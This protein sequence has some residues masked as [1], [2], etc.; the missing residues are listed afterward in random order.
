[1][2][3]LLTFLALYS[4]TLA[5][6][7]QTLNGT[8]FALEL[9]GLRVDTSG[10]VDFFE[11]DSFPKEKWFHEVRIVIN[12]NNITVNKQ[13]VVFDSSGNKV[14]SA[15]DGGFLT[16]KG[17]IAK[18][19]TLF[20]ATTRLTDYDYIGFSIFETP[21]LLVDTDSAYID[22]VLLNSKQPDMAELR[23]T[24]DATK[25]LRGIE[26]FLPKGTLRQDFVIRP[27]KD[28]LWVNNVFY[29]RRKIKATNIRLERN[30]GKRS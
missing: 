17:S 25:G 2:K 22:T 18:T 14:Y 8:Y 26:V 1:M 19:G 5:G 9:N 3:E 12:G 10:K 4:L 7:A 30:T 11:S 20:L 6:Q 23:K 16:Y 24:Y 28:G 27:D 21:K 29:Y 15:S 13:P